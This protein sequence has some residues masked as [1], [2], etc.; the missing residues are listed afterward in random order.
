MNGQGEAAWLCRA[1]RKAAGVKLMVIEAL[2]I[3]LC[4][5]Q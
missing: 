3:L 2:E 4:A 1:C 5:R